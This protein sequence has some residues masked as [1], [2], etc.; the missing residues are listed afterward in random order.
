MKIKSL[1][2]RLVCVT[3]GILAVMVA[4]LPMSSRAASVYGMVHLGERLQSGDIRAV[5]LG[6]STQMFVDS[7]AVLHM[8]TALL[9]KIPRVTIGANQFVGIDEAT[10]DDYSEQDISA[11]FSGFKFVFPTLG[12]LRLA[13]GYVGRF[14]PDGGFAT[15][16]STDSGDAYTNLYTRAGSFFSVPITI[17]F[18][19]SRFASVGLTFSFEQ[20]TVEDEFR[21]EF[22]NDDIFEP[23]AGIKKEDLSG[24]AFAGDVA[25]Y[26]L[27]GLVLGATYQSK[28]DYDGEAYEDYYQRAEWDTSYATTVSIPSRLSVGGSWLIAE[29]YLFLASAAFSDFTKFNG[30]V[31]PTDRLTKERE[32]AFGF[33]YVRGI[34]IKSLR[35]PLRVSF[36]YYTL[37]FDY[38]QGQEISRYLVGFGTGFE[39][40]QGRGKI[41]L[42]FLVGKQ[43]SVADNGIEDRL[44]R[45]YLGLSGSEL[46]KRKGGRTR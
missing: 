6:G 43:G 29:D 18:N 17:A 36:N 28:I 13:V 40:G 12:G 25:F 41:D 30:L 8:N 42:G 46:W 4:F 15:R 19:A 16:G 33:E 24:H 21:I 23:S 38:P 1:I 11:V 9:A 37:P 10:T 2:P 31:F 14:N 27:P 26:P 5:T 35:M 7:L 32:Y 45:I 20:G 22:D 3:L 39:Y 44:I 34:R